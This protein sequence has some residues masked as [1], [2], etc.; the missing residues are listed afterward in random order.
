MQPIPCQAVSDLFDALAHPVRVR[1]VELLT[2]RELCVCEIVAL[3]GRRQAYVS[4]QLAVLRQ[5]G[6]VCDR[7]EGLKV[8]YRLA[9]DGIAEL[10]IRAATLS[11]CPHVA[12]V[13]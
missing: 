12:A 5:A 6:I 4:Q 13:A 11:R 1:I 8:Y 7:R 2:E 9:D 3:L 10:V